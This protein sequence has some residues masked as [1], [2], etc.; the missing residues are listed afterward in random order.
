MTWIE[1]IP[2]DRAEGELAS[3]YEKAV[4]RRSGRV[5]RILT[6]HSLHPAGLAGHLELYRAVMRG[7]ETLTRAE[8][9]MIAVTVSRIND[10][11]Y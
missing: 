9:E 6:C 4:D 11:H 7:T 3:L 1:Q 10:C 2:E 5:D 8:R